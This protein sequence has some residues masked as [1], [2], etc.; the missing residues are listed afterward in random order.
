MLEEE[1]AG[2]NGGSW[3][4]RPRTAQTI[5]RDGGAGERG[6]NEYRQAREAFREKAFHSADYKVQKAESLEY[7]VGDRVR[8][9]KFGEG[10]VDR[11]VD[12][13]RDFEVT[14]TFD[15]AG[16][17]KMFAAFAKLKKV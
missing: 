15:K 13:G 4:S 5:L 16:V 9:I 1:E 8:H 7:T 6:R 17:K 12:G 3:S 10:T 2:G 11:I 14:V